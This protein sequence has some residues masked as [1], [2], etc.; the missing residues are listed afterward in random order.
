MYD[1]KIFSQQ[2]KYKNNGNNG[3]KIYEMRAWHILEELVK[4]TNV[5]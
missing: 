3:N 4:Y 2:T 1:L 5:R